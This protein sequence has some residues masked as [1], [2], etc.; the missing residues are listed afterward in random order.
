MCENMNCMTVIVGKAASQTG[1]VLVA[2]NEDDPGHVVVRHAYV[3]CADH[4][5]GELIPCEEG[6]ASIPQ[7]SHTL[8]FYWSEF[9]AEKGGLTAA[10]AFYNDC[11]VVITSNSMGDSKEDSEDPSVVKNGGLGYVLRRAL[12]ERAQS[13]RDGARILME[14]INEWGYAPSGRAYTIAD[15]DEAFMFQLVRGRHYIGARIPD[16]AVAVMPNHYNFHTLSDCPEMFYPEDIV[17]YAVQKGWYDPSLGTFDF[18]DAYQA[19][20][21]WHNRGNTLRQQY[22]QAIILDRKWDWTKDGL[23]FCVFPDR[24]IGID[25]LAEVMSTHYKGTDD[26][27]DFYGPGLSPHY[28]PYK[29]G[30]RRI[31]TGTTLESAIYELAEEAKET[32]VYVC[33]GRPCQVPYFPIKPLKQ[34][35]ESMKENVDASEML[36]T[37]LNPH[38]GVTEASKTLRGRFRFLC[39]RQEMIF[40]RAADKM[41]PVLK[42]ILNEGK[43]R[44]D[45]DAFMLEA[46]NEVENFVKDNFEDTGLIKIEALERSTEN[47]T[48]AFEAKEAP[49]E[50]T[51]CF[52][53]EF[54]QMIEA[55]SKATPGSLH[56]NPDGLWTAVFP[57]KPMLD[58]LP[59]SGKQEM[60]LGGRTE[61][62]KSFACCGVV[63][64]I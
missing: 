25:T 20:A 35:P 2:H 41:L 4:A 43:Q 1:H 50:D 49:A 28:A 26:D 15:K 18:A 53:I 59:F 32:K 34:L 23:P 36:K 47:V 46:L 51:L 12:A 27:V 62:G 11:G 44:N 17:S 29:K 19:E 37:H 58:L 39:C 55:F 21:S 7:V 16:D 56:L 45:Y 8:G 57:L 64:I 31:C 9:V 40:D 38:S 6:L 30:T 5:A 14:L 48:V 60:W 54:T 42:G 10:D 22:G 52:G 33:M 13:A 61:G 3:P 63:N 24:K